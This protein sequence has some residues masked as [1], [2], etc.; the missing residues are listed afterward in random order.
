MIACSQGSV[1]HLGML[2]LLRPTRSAFIGRFILA[3]VGEV[4][5]LKA[6]LASLNALILLRIVR[7]LWGVNNK[8]HIHNQE[9]DN[10]VRC[11][12]LPVHI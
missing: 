11:I 5:I 12:F 7:F 8:C 2:Q 9:A 6:F 10:G 4:T 3:F 1:D